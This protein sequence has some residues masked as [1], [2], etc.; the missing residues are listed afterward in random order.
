MI[1]YRNLSE[2]VAQAG[3]RNG[4]KMPKHLFANVVLPRTIISAE[5]QEDFNR[6]CG[7]NL[8]S[9]AFVTTV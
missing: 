8:E 1:F 9:V 6:N 2:I 7:N 5:L 3:T 4:D